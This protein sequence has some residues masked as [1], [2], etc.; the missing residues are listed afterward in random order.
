V[1]SFF[2]QQLSSVVSETHLPTAASGTVAVALLDRAAVDSACAGADA[3]L[4]RQLWPSAQVLLWWDE[5]DALIGSLGLF[6]PHE[7][8]AQGLPTHLA[9]LQNCFSGLVAVASALADK[10]CGVRGIVGGGDP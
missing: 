10:H 1:D 6:A 2:K 4:R 9:D 5:A 7:A 8:C 3:D